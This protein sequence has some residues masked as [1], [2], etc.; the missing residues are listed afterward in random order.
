M[1]PCPHLAVLPEGV[2]HA[3]HFEVLLGHLD[4][5]AHGARLA[6]VLAV[7]VRVA[8]LE[9]HLVLLA[10]PARKEITMSRPR[11]FA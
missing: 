3:A 5:A 8:R 6:R 10:F 2:A 1:R 4:L 9:E 7:R 11:H